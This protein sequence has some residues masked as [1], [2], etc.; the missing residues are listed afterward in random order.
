MDE[1]LPTTSLVHAAFTTCHGRLI[2]YNYLDIVGERAA[3]HDTDSIC[4]LSVPGLPDPPLGPYLGDLTDQLEDDYGPGSFCTEF[5][6]AGA[7]N[8]SYKVAVRG[9]L[10]N[11]KTVIKVRG[12]SINNSCSDTVTFDRLKDMVLKDT[13]KAKINI[14][15]QI[16][17]LPGWRIVTRSSS[18]QW[19]V[20]LNKRRRI[21]KEKTVPY[22][23]NSTLL[24]TDDFHL[25][26]AL[27]C[28]A[29][30]SEDL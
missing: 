24:D 12:I 21:D 23:Y 30:S 2:L 19:Q 20:C 9:D 11:I 4:F 27:E 15:A 5:V 28:L 16:V 10:Q 17:R 13:G 6:S 3:Y 14:P 29:D 26:S 7:K 1:C 25:L 22:G 18:K 8:Y